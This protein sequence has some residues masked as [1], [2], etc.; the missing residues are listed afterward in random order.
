MILRTGYQT[1]EFNDA[2]EMR[3]GSA[4][5]ALTWLRH[6]GY[7]DPDLM[8]QLRDVAAQFSEEPS[9][10]LTDEQILQRVAV[11]LHTRRI[12]VM[13]REHRTPSGQPAEAAPAAA[14]AFPL[15]ERTTRTASSSP[16]PP[17]PASDPSTFGPDSAASTQA[18][19]L[20][21]AAAAGTPFCQE[22]S[23]GS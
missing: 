7:P 23:K 4:D 11:L 8:R 9:D 10:R 20:V 21:A 13:G 2:R 15:S 6:L 19:A 3:F 17:P 18:A 14:P 1:F 22:C 12:T 16:P 5:D